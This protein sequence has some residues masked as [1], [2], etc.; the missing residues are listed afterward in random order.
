MYLY[1]YD[2]LLKA[3]QYER[4]LSTLETKLIDLGI[5]GKTVRL[6]SLLSPKQIISD[7]TRRSKETKTVV[8]IGDDTSFTKIVQQAADAPVTFGWVPIGPE[9]NLAERLGLPYGAAAAQVLSQRRVVSVDVG[10]FNQYFF[11]D[12]CRIPLT[13]VAM[14][15]NGA[16]TI[17]GTAQQMQCDIWNMAPHDRTLLPPGYV[18][19]PHDRQLEIVL[20]PVA[21]RRLFGSTLASA[22]IFPF[23]EA[24]L[25][26]EK[27]VMV[28]VDGRTYK[29]NQIVIR[30]A[31]QPLKLIVSRLTSGTRR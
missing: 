1:L 2:G 20:Q 24:R 4:A 16:I 27:T 30:M 31:P 8:V 26:F 5:A 23:T 21:K 3:R 22:S 10:Q 29:E 9:T 13:N 11:I 25:K 15:L 17:S 28:T 18:P 6:S 19:S 14:S 7:E 12:S